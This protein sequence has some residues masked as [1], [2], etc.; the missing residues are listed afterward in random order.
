LKEQVSQ[1]LTSSWRMSTDFNA[2]FEKLLLPMAV[3]HN[4]P[5]ED[6]VKR[7]FVF[8]DMQ[9]D[10]AGDQKGFETNYERIKRLYEEAGYDVPEMVFWNLAGGRGGAAPKPVTK[11]ATGT[12]LVSGY[13]QGMLKVLLD[14]GSFDDEGSSDDKEEDAGKDVV[15]INP[16][17]TVMKAIGHKSYEMLKVVD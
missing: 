17:A 3:N 12:A 16:L 9:F 13:S 5:K 8:S 4:I 10:E 14:G 2:V 7:I 15:K 11:D 1:M 6:M